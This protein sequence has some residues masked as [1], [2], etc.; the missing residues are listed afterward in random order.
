MKIVVFED[1][2]VDDFYPITLTRP[3][4]D[5]RT[6]TYT[7]GER[8]GKWVDSYLAARKSCSM[9]LYSRDM[10]AGV[11][12]E[13]YSEYN[14]NSNL[15]L[16]DKA[17]DIV[18]INARC[19]P[20]VDKYSL[21]K[22]VLY[23]SG[24]IPLFLHLDNENF[25]E[26]LTINSNSDILDFIHSLHVKKEERVP[27]RWIKNLWE[28]VDGNAGIIID[29]IRAYPP[30]FERQ[31][32]EHITVIGDSSYLYIEQGV[33]V[34]PFVVCDCTRGPI[35]IQKGAKIASFTRIEGPCSIGE[36]TQVTGAKIREGCSFGPQCRIGGEIE[37][38]VFQGYV[39]KYHEGFIGHSFIGEWVNLGA[40]TS[41]SDLKNNYTPVKVSMG[42]GRV[43]TGLLKVGAFIGDFT[44]TSIGTL[45]NTGSVMGPGSMIIHGGS[46]TPDFVPPF[47]WYN[48]NALTETPRFDK[49][50]ESCRMMTSRRGVQFSRNYENM[51]TGI[52]DSSTRVRGKAIEKWNSRLK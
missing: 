3:V 34:D 4:W 41:N 32:S 33:E 6:G 15:Q 24:D 21:E 45:I 2:R 9:Y 18:F 29:D 43:N 16:P 17:K 40:L 46:L 49:F 23:A 48:N 22:N 36:N 13:R 19:I 27:F 11:F 25:S 50:I 30:D 51:L 31:P 52:Y 26:K 28:L 37:E 20:F 44:M 39:N 12:S 7:M 1:T 14:I 5:L 35:L 10:V 47:T 42:E 8:I 38:S